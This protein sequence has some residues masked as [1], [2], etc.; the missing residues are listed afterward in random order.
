MTFNTTSKYIFSPNLEDT[1]LENFSD[2]LE[3]LYVKTARKKQNI[4]LY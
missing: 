1:V 2:I 4:W 3:N